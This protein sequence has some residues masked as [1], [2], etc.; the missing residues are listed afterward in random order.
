MLGLHIATEMW[1][2]KENIIQEHRR[3]KFF[4]SALSNP[5]ACL[6]FSYTC[7]CI[8]LSLRY[9]FETVLRIKRARYKD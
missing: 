6:P 4:S 1:R 8:M 9:S 7:T 2:L 5:Q 3:L